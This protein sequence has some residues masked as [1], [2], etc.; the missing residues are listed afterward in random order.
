MAALRQQHSNSI[1][2]RK[3]PGLQQGNQQCFAI[4]APAKTSYTAQLHLASNT[5]ASA[6]II[7]PANGILNAKS[8][9][10]GYSIQPP[11]LA[12]QQDQMSQASV[13]YDP[14][15][16][17]ASHE[18]PKQGKMEIPHPLAASRWKAKHNRHQQLQ[19][20]ARSINHP[21]PG[22]GRSSNQPFNQ[23]GL[24][25]GSRSINTRFRN[26]QAI[27]ESYGDWVWTDGGSGLLF[28]VGGSGPRPSSC[29]F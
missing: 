27:A 18:R 13:E 25:P 21:M 16:A 3:N 28:M 9:I 5:A 4:S 12:Q 29:H 7:K 11:N 24:L 14:P 2:A 15:S 23:M 6:T 26:L 17:Q 8:M 20:N 22:P 1:I 10:K 19:I